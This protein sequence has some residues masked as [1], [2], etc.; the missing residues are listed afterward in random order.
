MSAEGDSLR[1]PIEIKPE[2][3][4]EIRKLIEEITAAEND[5]RVL[6]PRRGKGL[7]DESSR[8]AFTPTED[9]RGGLFGGQEG[10]ALPQK[11][12]DRTSKAPIQREN[13]FKKLQNQVNQVQEQQLNPTAVIGGVTQGVGFA[14]LVGQGRLPASALGR[15][16]GL[17]SKAFLPLAIITTIIELVKTVIT[18]ALAPGGPLDRRFKRD[19]KTEVVNTISL[20]RKEEVNQGFRVIRTQVY[21]TLRGE[22]G[23]FSNL[24]VDRQLYDIGLASSMGGVP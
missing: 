2:D 15:V 24:R 16:A 8:S 12:R 18:A 20:E 14:Q 7:G 6:K 4:D 23:T 22:A 10:D 19:I 1:I 17:A 9:Q 11:G 21:P 13:E 3:S 5:L